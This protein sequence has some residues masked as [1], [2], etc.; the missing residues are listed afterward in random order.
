MKK[1]SSCKYIEQFKS[2]IFNM[3]PDESNTHA[4][5]KYHHCKVNK[6]SNAPSFQKTQC[7]IFGNS[8]LTKNA[9]VNEVNK[10]RKTGIRTYCDKN[11]ESYNNN[12]KS[13]RVKDRSLR[14]VSNKSSVFAHWN[15]SDYKVK[16]K[17]IKNEYNPDKFFNKETPAQRHMNEFHK[18]FKSLKNKNHFGYY[19]NEENKI[20]DLQTVR[21]E[22][23]PIKKKH[24]W[25]NTNSADV[26][27]I[28]HNNI[29][30]STSVDNSL[31]TKR[32]DEHKRQ[33]PSSVL[34]TPKINRLIELRSN[35]FHQPNNNNNNYYSEQHSIDHTNNAPLN[36]DNKLIKVKHSVWPASKMDWITENTELMFKNPICSIKGDPYKNAF[37]RKQMFF[38]ESND[39]TVAPRYRCSS[40]DR[41]KN[42]DSTNNDYLKEYT[43]NKAQLKKKLN[44]NDNTKDVNRIK[45]IFHHSQSPIKPDKEMKYTQNI[46]SVGF[47]DDFYLRNYQYK[48]AQHNDNEH[49]YHLTLAKDFK[50]MDELN[51]QKLFHKEGLH[52]YDIQSQGDGLTLKIR[53]NDHEQ[54]KEK[55]NSVK[56]KLCKSEGVDIT[57]IKKICVNKKQNAGGMNMN[58]KGDRVYPDQDMS[59]PVYKKRSNDENSNNNN[60]QKISKEFLLV[61]NKYKNNPPKKRK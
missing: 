40:A 57:P 54:F 23:S 31:I 48:H 20:N 61:N 8:M 44:I 3:Q 10:Q 26:S 41:N 9:D 42:N 38:T 37:L 19:Q 18:N 47:D 1:S 21:N 7:N 24:K 34:N 27:Y 29:N 53:E 46:S 13:E 43:L 14:N 30:N 12:I 39:N 28:N 16:K 32:N 6:V 17:E 59:K 45:K 22:I 60:K 15:D 51:I 11:N 35:I 58:W 5:N 55:F 4:N 50:G 49:R 56:E 2:D 25:L 36:S 33:Q 52:V